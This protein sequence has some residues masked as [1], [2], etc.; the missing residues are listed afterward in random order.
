MGVN[1]AM[2]RE[3]LAANAK[4]NSLLMNDILILEI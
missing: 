1:A 4:A 3:A 2:A